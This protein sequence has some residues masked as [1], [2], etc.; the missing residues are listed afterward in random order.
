MA[1]TCKN[2]YS[3]VNDEHKFC[4]KCGTKIVE[5]VEEEIIVNDLKSSQKK[6]ENKFSGSLTFIGIILILGLI[7]KLTFFNEN[8]TNEY[9][10]EIIK[11]KSN[12][13]SNNYSSDNSSS[14]ENKESLDNNNISK[15]DTKVENQKNTIIKEKITITPEENIQ[16]FIESVKR[17]DKNKIAKFFEYPI[18]LDPVIPSIK[19]NSELIEKFDLVFDPNI[20]N[21]IANS[22]INKDWSAVGSKGIMFKNGDIWFDYYGTRISHIN[23]ATNKKKELKQF[24]QKFQRD[25]LH[26]SLKD[27]EE[28]IIQASTEKYRI[29]IDRLK[30][31]NYRY[32]SWQINKQISDIP[33]LVLVNGSI[34]YYGSSGNY[35]FE[36]RNGK[37]IYS[38]FIN[39][40]D[41]VPSQLYIKKDGILL[42]ETN[43][44]E[45]N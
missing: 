42:L 13:Q 18:Y 17:L 14:V 4:T 30:N 40:A 6:E 3:S 2:C 38:C 5:Q 22:K 34:E 21:Q 20:I 37:Y 28:S 9:K 1:R 33:S 29:R 10:E 24:I 27:F 44:T 11:N 26:S 12:V 15:I 43:F 36:F 8:H 45:I 23:Y 35:G 16:E 32:A 39:K 19:N 31:G 7:G 25:T 41:R